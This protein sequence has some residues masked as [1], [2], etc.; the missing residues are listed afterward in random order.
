MNRK[1]KNNR[2]IRIKV[3]TKFINR[4]SRKET[5]YLDRDHEFGLNFK[6][7]NLMLFLL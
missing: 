7:K 2:N 6:S 3:I 1:V 5:D 4:N